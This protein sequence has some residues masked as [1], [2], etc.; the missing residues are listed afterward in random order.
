LHPVYFATHFSVADRAVEFPQE[1]AII[2]GHAE[3]DW[4]A[5]MTW[6]DACDLG[7]RFRQHANSVVEE[8]HLFV[9]FCDSRR[10]VV[11][12]GRFRE[13]LYLAKPMKVSTVKP[14]P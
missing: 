10:Q 6:Q 7:L 3:P 2:T 4:T 12:V 9:T 11:T 1:F 14:A 8:D 5:Q 13:R